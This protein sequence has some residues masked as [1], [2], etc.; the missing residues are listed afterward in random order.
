M[1][2]DKCKGRWI[3][4]NVCY[5]LLVIKYCSYLYLYSYVSV[6]LSIYI[7]GNVFCL[8]HTTHFRMFLTFYWQHVLTPTGPSADRTSTIAL[9]Y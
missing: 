4:C 5:S 1:L 9:C 7:I 8:L 2:L 6:V 3:A